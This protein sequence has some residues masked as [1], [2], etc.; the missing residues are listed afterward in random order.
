MFLFLDT[1]TTGLPDFR[2][3]AD[4]PGQPRIASIAMLLCEP[5]DCRIVAV[6]HQLVRPA[7]WTVSAEAEAVHGLSTAMLQ[8]YG[9]DLRFALGWFTLNTEATRPTIVGHS[10]AFDLKMLRGELRRAGMPDLYDAAPTYCTMHKSRPLLRDL[11]KTPK[12]T[13][14]LRILCGHTLAD[15]HDVLADTMGARQLF[16]ELRRR[17]AGP[18]AAAEAPAPAPA[19]APAG[20]WDA[21]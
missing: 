4:D 13:E 7:G 21:L 16:I 8:R 3:P 17:G 6:H 14:A 20:T 19:A 11:K 10:I 9:A 18:A 2:K 5:V 15:A 12:L 1:E